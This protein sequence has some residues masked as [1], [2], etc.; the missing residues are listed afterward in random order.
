MN[1]DRWVA[2]LTAV[3]A[4]PLRAAAG[5]PRQTISGTRSLWISLTRKP[6]GAAPAA[7]ILL[8]VVTALLAGVLAPY[9]PLETHP[10]IRLS[11]P[12]RAHV[13][14]TDDIGA[15]SSA[16]SSTAAG[17]RCGSASSRWGSGRSPA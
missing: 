17:S 11:A 15:T 13:F 2:S 3:A 14:G 16:A 10:D 4:A 5:P 8:L 12:S 1:G 6:L 9:D 7:L